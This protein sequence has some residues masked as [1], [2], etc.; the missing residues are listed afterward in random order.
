[1]GELEW[2]AD[3][4]SIER[5]ARDPLRHYRWHVLPKSGGGVRLAAAPKPRLKEAQR[6]L[7]RHVVAPIPVHVAAH[8]CEP[9]RSVRSALLPHCGSAIVVRFDLEGFFAHVRAGRIWSLLRDAGLPEEVAH[10][11]TGLAT[12]VVPYRVLSAH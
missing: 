3:V 12:T 2:F 7:L 4:R 8:G 1:M 6:R 11:V 5:S 9:A 10:T